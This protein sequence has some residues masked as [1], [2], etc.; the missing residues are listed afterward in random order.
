MLLSCS[1]NGHKGVGSSEKNVP[2]NYAEDKHGQA[3]GVHPV[4]EEVSYW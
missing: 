1:F 4:S 2:D 3:T